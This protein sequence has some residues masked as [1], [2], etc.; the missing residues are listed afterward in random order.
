VQRA[1]DSPRSEICRW[2][3]AESALAARKEMRVSPSWTADN[4]WLTRTLFE[5]GLAL[6]YLNNALNAVQ[7]A[8]GRHGLLP[9]PA[10]IGRFRS[11]LPPSLFCLGPEGLAFSGGRLAGRSPLMLGS[12]RNRR[13][14]LD[15]DFGG[16]LGA[17]SWVWFAKTPFR[18][19]TLESRDIWA[20]ILILHAACH[21][22]V[23]R[24]SPYSPTA[25]PDILPPSAVPVNWK[26]T[27][28]LRWAASSGISRC[29]RLRYQ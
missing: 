10:W 13:A 19:E 9:A 18:A 6:V 3:E 24:A 22:A 25:M 4:Y 17:C 14:L 20:R 16:S 21:S 2:L 7:G 23:Q 27:P 12:D 11:A 8:A 28:C 26:L 29:W 15:L 1:G 5:R